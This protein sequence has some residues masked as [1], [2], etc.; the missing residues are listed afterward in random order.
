MKKTERSSGSDDLG[1]E[2]E[3]SVT[4]VGCVGLD[5]ESVGMMR[6]SFLSS[7]ARLRVLRARSGVSSDSIP[8]T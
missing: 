2:V 5:A 8:I 3:V 1:L 7:A 6:L 4:R